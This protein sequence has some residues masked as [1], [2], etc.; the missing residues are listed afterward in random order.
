M[1]GWTT[2]AAEASAR[3]GLALPLGAGVDFGKD[4]LARGFCADA[5]GLLVGW[6]RRVA[7]DDKGKRNREQ[8]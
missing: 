5:C 4:V 8:I 3:L 6:K 2:A 1:L 7:V